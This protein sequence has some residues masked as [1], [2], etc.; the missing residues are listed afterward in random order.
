LTPRKAKIWKQVPQRAFVFVEQAFNAIQ[1]IHSPG[2]GSWYCLLYAWPD[3]SKP[4][5]GPQ[6]NLPRGG[7][8]LSLSNEKKGAIVSLRNF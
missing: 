3:G 1:L 4:E 2:P 5:H 6:G 7:F 8:D